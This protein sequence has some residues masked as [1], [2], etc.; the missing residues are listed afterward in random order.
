MRHTVKILQSFG[1]SSAKFICTGWGCTCMRKHRLPVEGNDFI[2]DYKQLDRIINSCDNA[3][4]DSSYITL[5]N[6]FDN[7]LKNIYKVMRKCNC[8]RNVRRLRFVVGQVIHTPCGYEEHYISFLCKIKVCRKPS[9]NSTY[10]GCKV[11]HIRHES[12]EPDMSDDEEYYTV[13][14]E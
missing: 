6:N 11:Y 8:C 13:V 12:E 10:Q 3:Y 7:M 14:H 4:Y 1:N 2:D 5:P 9:C